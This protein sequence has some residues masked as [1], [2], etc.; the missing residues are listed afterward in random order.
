[1]IDKETHAK[2]RHLFYAEH[3]K[4][5]TIAH[6]LGLHPD[7]VRKAIESDGFN[8]DRVLR[9]RA[10]DP[11]VE[12]IRATLEKYPG[13]RATRIY[14]MIRDRGYTGSVIQLR[15]VVALLVP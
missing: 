5:G 1:M 15:R 10:T 11:Y 6:E 4:I 2:I 7:T 14:H 13:L 3:W 8:R 12:F 9:P